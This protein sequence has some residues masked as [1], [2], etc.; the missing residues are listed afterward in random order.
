MQSEF[1]DGRLYLHRTP[2]ER[3]PL[4]KRL[5]RI[6]GQVR[7]LRQMIEEDRYCPDEV[8]QAN[9]ITA[10]VR[11]VALLVIQQHLAASVEHAVTSGDGEAAVKDM[12]AV[13]RA[14]MRQQ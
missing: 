7:G 9:A 6:E 5:R 1:R 14:A 10:A 13:L 4:L 12:L 2:E 3:E 11:E 8:Q